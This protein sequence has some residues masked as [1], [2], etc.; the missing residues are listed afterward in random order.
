MQLD[1]GHHGWE[2][3]GDDLCD[4]IVRSIS[5]NNDGIIRVE[6][7]QDGCLCEGMFEGLKGCS[8][9]GTQVNGMSLRV[10][11]ISGITMS[12]NTT[13]NWR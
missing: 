13:M 4:R 6:M 5:L 7:R 3:S 8:V 11:Q 2:R 12:E 1:G 10:R 9:V